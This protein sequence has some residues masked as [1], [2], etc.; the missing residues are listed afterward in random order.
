MIYIL[1]F[2]IFI[3]FVELLI[4]GVIFSSITV[5]ID[6]LEINAINTQI[7]IDTMLISLDIKLYKVLKILK[8]KFYRNYFKIWW[9]KINY[10][11][12]LK[13]DTRTELGEKAYEFFKKNKIK[14][15][16]IKPEI[17]YFKFDLNFGTEDAIITSFF[18]VTLSGLLTMLFCKCVKKFNRKDYIFKITPNYFNRNN[19]NFKFKSKIN[20]NTLQLLGR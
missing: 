15:K 10:K 13:Y 8:I 3:I 12:A 14:I 7:N 20:F 18:T 2:L 6:N 11:K 16:N 4:L 9:I 17:K 19:F 5:N 1:V